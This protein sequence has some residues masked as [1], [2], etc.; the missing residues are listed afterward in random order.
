MRTPQSPP[1]FDELTRELNVATQVALR[2]GVT[3]TLVDGKYVHWEK[4]RRLRLPRGIRNHKEWWAGLKFQRLPK[5]KFINLDIFEETQFSFSLE[6]PIYEKHIFIDKNASGSIQMPV[7]IGEAEMKKQFYVKSLIE[8][9]I[10]SSQMEG[11]STTRPV[12]KAMILDK[13][14]PRDKSEQMILNN[15]RTMEFINEIKDEPLSKK[16]IFEIHKMISENTFDDEEE[17]G[18]FRKP[19]EK[20]VVQDS[21]TGEIFHR[22]PPA[23]QLEEQISFLCD[24]AN[25]KSPEYFVH[26]VIRSVILHFLIGF[27]HP[28]V[29][30]NGRT[31]RAL[32]YWS[33]LHHGYWLFQY[34]SISRILK[35]EQ[36][37]YSQSY[38]FTENDDNDLNY[39]LVYH[40]DVIERAIFA[41]NDFVKRKAIQSLEL[42]Q[43]LK[44][45]EKFNYRQ[46]ELLRHAIQNPELPYTFKSHQTSHGISYASSRSDILSLVEKGLLRQYKVGRA[47]HFLP[48][49]DIKNKLK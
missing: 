46:Q 40:L 41:C 10:T 47:M 16:L 33:M 24:F 48:E 2:M 25:E 13:R 42:M 43:E 27:I 30:G 36:K 38:L 39:F 7:S 26:P 11:A 21:L 8:E 12:A 17:V 4:L 23:N 31:A 15:Y 18:R 9:A 45:M 44:S 14:E 19:D 34:I 37:R 49:K 35:K 6:D 32:F 29:D 22:P 1:N 3:S 5:R 28:F 20:V